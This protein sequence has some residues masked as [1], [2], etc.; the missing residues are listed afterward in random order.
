MQGPILEFYLMWFCFWSFLWLKARDTFTSSL[1]QPEFFQ[2]NI[3]DTYGQTGKGQWCSLLRL[4]KE[5]MGLQI[6]WQPAPEKGCEGLGPK[7]WDVPAEKERSAVAGPIAVEKEW[8]VR[9][10]IKADVGSSKKGGW[11]CIWQCWGQYVRCLWSWAENSLSPCV[12]L[13]LF[14]RKW[15]LDHDLCVSQTPG[16]DLNEWKMDGRGPNF[17]SWYFL[18]MPSF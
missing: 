2:Y 10:D 4:S 11:S 7:S 14:W 12:L 6:H 5:G 17:L 15:M 18:H 3:R 1:A 13:S 16:F 8:Q 9:G